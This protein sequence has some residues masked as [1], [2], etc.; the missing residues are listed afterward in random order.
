MG[1]PWIQSRWK[2]SSES[3]ATKRRDYSDAS[4]AIAEAGT[5]ASRLNRGEHEILRLTKQDASDHL[6]AVELLKPLNVSL[7]VAVNEYV[8]AAKALQGRSLVEVAKDFALR[9]RGSVTPRSVAVVVDELLSE[10]KREGKSQRYLQSL[11]SHLHRFRDSFTTEIGS[12]TTLQMETWL[13]SIGR[14]PRT[15]NNIRSSLVTL[16][17]FARKRGY[18]PRG[19]ATEADEVSRN[20]VA[21]SVAN[22][23]SPAEL[24]RLLESANE[25]VLPAI[26][27]GAFTGL[28]SA[29]IARLRWEN[30][31]WSQR[32][33]EVPAAIAK[34][35]KR[36]LVPLLPSLVAWL[37][38]YRRKVGRVFNGERIQHHLADAFATAKVE[39]L[40]NGLRDSFISYRVAATMNLPQVAY[41]AGNSVE[42]IRS[43]Y[44]E[45]RTKKEAKAWFAVRPA[46]PVNVVNIGRTRSAK[47]A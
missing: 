23:Y 16:F 40:H 10:R 26:A 19:I 36:Y 44:L 24:Q 41:E 27:I 28:R 13:S 29:T 5:I 22:I 8:H 3:G 14:T 35:R 15:R 6:Q 33:M 30:I 21:P 31:R 20:D 18:L 12:V 34:N 46:R 38:A 7:L 45:A 32:V 42:M 2:P 17:Q 43:K 25:R 11:R 1:T 9:Q 39:R 4:E 37:A 47:R